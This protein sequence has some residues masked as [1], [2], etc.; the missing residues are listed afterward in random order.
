MMEKYGSLERVKSKFLLQEAFLFRKKCA[1]RI[2]ELN[3]KI[4]LPET[5]ERDNSSYED[6]MQQSELHT[7]EKMQRVFRSG[8]PLFDFSRS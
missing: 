6:G 8:T 7:M 5:T 2:S 3:Q 1:Q 4:R